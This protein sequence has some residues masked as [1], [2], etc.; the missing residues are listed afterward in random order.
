VREGG[1][2]LSPAREVRA[3]VVD[4]CPAH[5][6]CLLDDVKLY[7]EEVLI[8]GRVVAASIEEG[9]VNAPLAA[10]YERLAPA[11]FLE[12]GTYAGPGPV[13]RLGHR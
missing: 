1:F 6:E 10:P 3:P 7:A 4:E 8:F 5:L 13:K 9:C 11:F 12:A 2:T